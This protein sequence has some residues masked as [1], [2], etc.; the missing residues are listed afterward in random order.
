MLLPQARPQ[1][2][3]SV[4]QGFHFIGGGEAGSGIGFEAAFEDEVPPAAA[5][6]CVLARALSNS[7]IADASASSRFPGLLASL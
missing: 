2:F 1:L 3:Y 7:A 5:R 6:A 4:S